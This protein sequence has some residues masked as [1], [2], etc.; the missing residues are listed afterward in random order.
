MSTVAS[1]SEHDAELEEL[2]RLN[3]KPGWNRRALLTP[4]YSPPET[5][6]QRH[7]KELNAEERHSS[8]T[9]CTLSMKFL[10]NHWSEF[11]EIERRTCYAKQELSMQFI[12]SIWTQLDGGQKH[13]VERCQKFTPKFIMQQW[14]AMTW[15]GQ[16]NCIVYQERF[17]AKLVVERWND[18]R[19]SRHWYRFVQRTKY[20][21]S[22]ITLE[23]LPEYLSCEIDGIRLSAEER[24]RELGGDRE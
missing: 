21:C 10:L 8:V 1:I 3:N 9:H 5:F 11:T 2:W 6:V 20:D 17:P 7:W 22:D 24:L 13:I 23:E 12:K 19:N 4:K 18:L 14:N 16:C 15:W